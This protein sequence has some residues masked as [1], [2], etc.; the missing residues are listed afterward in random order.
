MT[1]SFL[2]CL[3]RRWCRRCRRMTK[4]FL[5]CL[6]RRWCRRSRRTTKMF[7]LSNVR[8]WCRRSWMKSSSERPQGHQSSL[9][10]QLRRE[11]GQQ[12]LLL[13]SQ[14]HHTLSYTRESTTVDL[15]TFPKAFPK[16]TMRRPF[17][18]VVPHVCATWRVVMRRRKPRY[19]CS[20][21]EPDRPVRRVFL[22]GRLRFYH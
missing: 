18:H 6:V 17:P 11:Q 1:K 9:V 3:V 8:R 20:L 14:S 15:G 21:R 10:P 7:H 16:F 12:S 19:Y 22:L 4:S 13:P 5:G 2:G